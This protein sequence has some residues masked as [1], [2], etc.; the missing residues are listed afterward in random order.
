MTW[1]AVC[2]E[3]DF[4]TFHTLWPAAALSAQ[5]HSSRLGHA[6]RTSQNLTRVRV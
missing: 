3:C 2:E 5:A 1:T 4:Q 6:V